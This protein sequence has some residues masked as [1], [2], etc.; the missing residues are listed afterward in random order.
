MNYETLQ[1]Q[2]EETAFWEISI[3]RQTRIKN[4]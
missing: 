1:I 4:K 2:I 3:N